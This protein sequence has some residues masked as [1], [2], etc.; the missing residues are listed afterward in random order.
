[1]TGYEYFYLSSEYL[2][3]IEKNV[4]L[5]DRQYKKKLLAEMPRRTSDRI[6]IKAA[7]KIEEVSKLVLLLYDGKR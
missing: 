6:A 2:P 3:D 5:R 4:Q 7:Q 1:M